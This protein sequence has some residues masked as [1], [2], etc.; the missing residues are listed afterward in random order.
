MEKYT[1]LKI[2]RNISLEQVYLIMQLWFLNAIDFF[3]T[4][5]AIIVS[6]N[7]SESNPII[8]STLKHVYGMLILK[9][10]VFSV[11]LFIFIKCL[12][13]DSRH[14]ENMRATIIILNS[15]YIVLILNN[16]IQIFF[17]LV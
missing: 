17:S 12:R 3:M 6:P 10:L 16:F 4:I 2:P 7:T 9:I 14:Y 8:S 1:Q 5:I 11:I 13:Y 15:F